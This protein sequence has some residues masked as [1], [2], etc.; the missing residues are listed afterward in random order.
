LQPVLIYVNISAACVWGYYSGFSR[1]VVA[2][3]EHF[4]HQIWAEMSA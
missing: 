4:H 1:T 3:V 2:S